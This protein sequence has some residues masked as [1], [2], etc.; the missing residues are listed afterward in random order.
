MKCFFNIIISLGLV[1]SGT[2]SFSQEVTYLKKGEVATYNGYLFSE[3]KEL[4][5]R[6]IS[7]EHDLLLQQQEVQN[8]IIEKLNLQLTYSSQLIDKEQNKAEVWRKA[9]EDSTKQLLSIQQSLT[10][11]K[12]LYFIGGI[13]VVLASAWTVGQTK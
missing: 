3:Q 1:L 12:Y 2:T 11:E 8:K 6:L 4:E 7:K 5:L 9:S 13:L 10:Y